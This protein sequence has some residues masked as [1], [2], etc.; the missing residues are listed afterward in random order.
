M[1]STREHMT[2]SVPSWS[3]NL[4]ASLL[5]T[6]GR[7]FTG[8]LGIRDMSQRPKGACLSGGGIHRLACMVVWYNS[9]SL[10]QGHKLS[11]GASSLHI[12]ISLHWV[13]MSHLGTQR[14]SLQRPINA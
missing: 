4:K 11:Q 8:T 9:A 6:L 13:E 1:L 14:Q 2:S 7:I 5:S 3:S 10:Q 12:Y